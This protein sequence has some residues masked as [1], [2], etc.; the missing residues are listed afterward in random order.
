M[1]D[2]LK[3]IIDQIVQL[4]KTKKYNDAEDKLLEA[5]KSYYNN[6]IVNYLLGT[7]YSEWD[8]P[9][10]AAEK[11]LHFF[12]LVIN[13]DHPIENAFI[14]LT[15]LISDKFKQISLLKKGLESFPQ[16]SKLFERLIF[17]LGNDE[18]I[19]LF[20]SLTD[21]SFINELTN[22]KILLAFYE[23]N[24]FDR[25]LTHSDKL[26]STNKDLLLFLNFILG[27]ANFKIANY[28][29]AVD[30]FIKSKEDDLKQQLNYGPNIGLL[31]CLNEDCSIDIKDK[32]EDLPINEEIDPSTADNF[33][34]LYFS[35]E[36]IF[37]TLLILQR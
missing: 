5:R 3:Q 17:R 21:Q 24:L 31:A 16:S 7:I 27:C 14:E 32:I 25:V 10:K 37:I 34:P 13:S 18:I 26:R 11:A 15:Y 9:L 22:F 2:N 33:I 12:E 35:F 8:S 30:L 19:Q 36:D 29:A 20:D 28:K 6:E 4:I 1:D 23:L